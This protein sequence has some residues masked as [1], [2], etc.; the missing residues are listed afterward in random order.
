MKSRF[1]SKFYVFS[2]LLLFVSAVYLPPIVMMISPAKAISEIEKRILAPFPQWNGDVQSLWKMPS[3]L[4]AYINDHIGFRDILAAG[5]SFISIQVFRSSPRSALLI[6][7]DGWF[8]FDKQKLS[9]NFR[10][11]D[12]LTSSNLIMFLQAMRCKSQWLAERGIR[13]LLM[14]TPEKQSIYPE[15]LPDDLQRQKG[16][17]RFDQVQEALTRG[18]FDID[19]RAFLDVRG[20]LL[21]E[22]KRHLVYY[23]TDTHWNFRGGLVAYEAL[24]KHLTTWFPDIVPKPR[25]FFQEVVLQNEPG[26]D[27]VQLVNLHGLLR[28]DRPIFQPK[29]VCSRRWHFPISN[30]NVPSF[31]MGCR[32]ERL[33]AVVFRDSYF[34]F[35][36]PFLSEHFQQI[37][38]I[39]SGYDQTILENVLDTFQPDIVIEEYLERY[40]T[41]RPVENR[42]SWKMIQVMSQANFNRAPVSLAKITEPEQVHPVHEVLLHSD[43][44]RISLHASGSDPYVFLEGIVV[45]RHAINLYMKIRIS[46]PAPTELQA[47]YLVSDNPTYDE[48]YSA[49]V[50]LSAGLN[51]VYLSLPG[52][53]FSGPIRLDPGK[54]PGTYEIESIDIR[55]DGIGTLDQTAIRK[56]S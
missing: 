38:Y 11:M 49:T 2:I 29:S 45:P 40:L 25:D 55:S 3:Q 26:G 24:T 47:F 20:A 33:K 7:K 1:E 48:A 39:W 14:I 32:K 44:S 23:R 15:Y 54:V 8:Y 35:V 34:N 41:S 19:P 36:L 4:N 5:S 53:D 22:K 52:T 27:L 46:A 51:T 18:Y 43:A 10:G 6:G 12:P 31:A 30:S 28:E 42:V 17:T 56:S 9:L 50:S 13:Y 21:A 37:V 16:K